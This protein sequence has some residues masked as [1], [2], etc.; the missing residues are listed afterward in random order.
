ME[1]GLRAGDP[2]DSHA[3]RVVVVEADSVGA[4]VGGR[5]RFVAGP[6]P[7]LLSPGP[8]GLRTCAGA[9]VRGIVH[10]VRASV[11]NSPYAALERT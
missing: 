6:D 2:S 4:C 8:S 1:R 10:P 7:G 3:I 11:V 9:W 5:G